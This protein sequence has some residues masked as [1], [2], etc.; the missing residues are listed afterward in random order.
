MIGTDHNSLAGYK[1]IA[2][3]ATGLILTLDTS[4]S[5]ASG[6]AIV[7]YFPAAVTAG[8]PLGCFPGSIKLDTVGMCFSEFEVTINNNITMR[9]NCFGSESASSFSASTFREVSFTG[10]LYMDANN[11]NLPQVS[12]GFQ[13]LAIEIIAGSTAGRI[14]TIAMPKAELNLVQ[15]EIP[16]EEEVTYSIEGVALAPTTAESEITMVFT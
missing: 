1:V 7:P 9:N 4:G 2:V 6:A 13:A 12:E 10:N 3:D 14:C 5:F 11:L 16:E 8:E 15:Y